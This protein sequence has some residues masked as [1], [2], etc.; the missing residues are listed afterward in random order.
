ME[1]IA[2]CMLGKYPAGPNTPLFSS[3]LV[4]G[5]TLEIFSFEMV[6][7]IFLVIFFK[8]FSCILNFNSITHKTYVSVYV[9]VFMCAYVFICVRVCECV[10]ACVNICKCVCM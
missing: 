1:P 9:C 7:V 8:H 4:K 10:C 6:I 3:M 5:R 2:L